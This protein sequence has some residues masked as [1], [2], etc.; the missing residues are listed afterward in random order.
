[1]KNN[2]DLMCDE[3]M[4]AY[5]DRFDMFKAKGMILRN[6]NMQRGRDL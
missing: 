6:Y 2:V 4:Q 1:M 5:Y 3:N